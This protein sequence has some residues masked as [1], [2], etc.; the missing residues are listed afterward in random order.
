MSVSDPIADMLNRI[1][2]AQMAGIGEIV[3]PHS[4][5]KGDIARLMQR[6]GYLDEVAVAGEGHQKMLR[7]ALKFL[8][9]REPGIRG[10]RRI[11]KPGLRQYATSANLPRVLGG[12]GIAI[13][14]TSSGIMTDR[15]ARKKKVGGE[16]LCH[17]W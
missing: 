16:V 2:N 5:I 13:L 8:G 14:S 3:M 17:V 1:R 9:T 6:E 11:S 10:L 4:K 12:M 15:E 7:I